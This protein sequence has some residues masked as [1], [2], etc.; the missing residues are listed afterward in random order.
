MFPGG[1]PGIALL[2]L[3]ASVATGFFLDGSLQATGNFARLDVV[4]RAVLDAALGLGVLTPLTALL[5]C[6]LAIVDVT[7]LGAMQAPVA[8]MT[9]VNAI[10]LG[11]LG[12]GAY[13]LDARLFGRRVLVVPAKDRDG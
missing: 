3:R 4:V 2:L 13:S 10:A 9:V 8:L 6:V 1:G 7:R 12:P 5:S 11:L